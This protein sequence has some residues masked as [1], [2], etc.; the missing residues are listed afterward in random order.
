MDE[1]EHAAIRRFLDRAIEPLDGPARSRLSCAFKTAKSVFGFDGNLFG[2]ATSPILRTFQEGLTYPWPR[3]DAASARSPVNISPGF[4]ERARVVA[5]NMLTWLAVG[6]VSATGTRTAVGRLAQADTK[7][8]KREVRAMQIC[9][10]C[11][12]GAL[13]TGRVFSNSSIR[14]PSGI[15]RPFEPVRYSSDREQVSYLPCRDTRKLR[16]LNRVAVDEGKRTALLTFLKV[17]A[18]NQHDSWQMRAPAPNEQELILGDRLAAFT[19]A[20]LY[21]VLRRRSAIFHPCVLL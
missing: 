9:W 18:Q 15:D 17:E 21:R 19:R 2:H 4:I 16:S 11:T 6:D 10:M 5:T 14:N 13:A 8:R 20:F 3:N 12:S 1:N 7:I